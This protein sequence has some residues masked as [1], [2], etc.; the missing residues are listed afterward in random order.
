MAIISDRDTGKLPLSIGTALAFEGIF[1]IHDTAVIQQP[2]PIYTA[3]E[4]WVNIKTLIRNIYGS[5]KKDV[6]KTLQ[7]RDYQETLYSEMLHIVDEVHRVSNG[8]VWVR[9]YSPT[10]R[11]L[12]TRYPGA[13]PKS[14]TNNRALTLR[15]IEQ[16]VIDGTMVQPPYPIEPINLDITAKNP[17]ILILTHQPIDLLNIHNVTYVGLMESHTGLVKDNHRWYTKLKGGSKEPRIP[18]NAIT[19]QIFGDTGDELQPAPIRLRHEM[20]EMA[21]KLKWTQNL[22]VSQMVR[23]I[24]TNGSPELKDL[25]KILG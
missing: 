3:D 14:E 17:K 21:D 8:R 6:L 22:T 2:Y 5:V 4:I 13:T 18:F 1:G 7:Y 11:S 12:L 23:A 24:Q 15:Q 25:V 19:I 9:F 10:H 20:I 16:W